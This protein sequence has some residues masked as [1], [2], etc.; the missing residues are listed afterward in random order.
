[1]YKNFYHIPLSIFMNSLRIPDLKQESVSMDS[2][3]LNASSSSL[4]FGITVCVECYLE[5]ACLSKQVNFKM[6]NPNYADISLERIRLNILSR[7]PFQIN[8]H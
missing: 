7:H 4:S 3:L 6:N 1:M 2:F 8:C 5:Y